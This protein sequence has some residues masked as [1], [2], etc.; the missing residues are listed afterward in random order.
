M[1]GIIGPMRG[2]DGMDRR[3][4]LT[5]A[6]GLVVLTAGAGLGGVSGCDNSGT[7]KASGLLFTT[8]FAGEPETAKGPLMMAGIDL[9]EIP[10]ADR[11]A[12]YYDGVELFNMDAAGAAL[13]MLADGE[14]AI[15]QIAAE[16][17]AKGFA[18]EPVDVALFFSSLSEAGY[19][20]NVV[21]VSVME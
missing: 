1:V 3:T 16:A 7:S 13:V 19:L 9:H 10:A 15:E 18:A 17:Q 12:A 11:V 8:P 4:F 2:G 21:R 20:R 6:F 14:R 5:G